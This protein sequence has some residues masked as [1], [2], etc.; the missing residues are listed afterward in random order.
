MYQGRRLHKAPES[1]MLL[2]KVVEVMPLDYEELQISKK[3]LTMI[4]VGT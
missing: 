4:T 2:Y 1:E 3:S